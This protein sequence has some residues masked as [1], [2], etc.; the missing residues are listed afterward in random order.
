LGESGR[1]GLGVSGGGWRSSSGSRFQLGR[2]EERSHW[3][4]APLGLTCMAQPV[5]CHVSLGSEQIKFMGSSKFQSRNY[6]NFV[7]KLLLCKVIVATKVNKLL[8]KLERN[9]TL[10]WLQTLKNA[11]SQGK[12]IIFLFVSCLYS[13]KKDIYS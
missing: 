3:R 13:E 2:G 1:P 9:F 10:L 12:K 7:L 5:S 11:T 8:K 4:S 6:N